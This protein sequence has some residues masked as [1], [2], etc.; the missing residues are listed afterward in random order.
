VAGFQQIA[1][2]GRRWH[3]EMK[4]MRQNL[5]R[6]KDRRVRQRFS[7]NAPLLVIAGDREIPAYTRDLSNLGVYFYL[8]S[9]DIGLVDRDFDFTLELPPEITLSTCC[10]IQCR[11]R[12]VRMET[13]LR[14]LTGVAAEILSY[15]IV[16]EPAA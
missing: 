8:G 2:H 10:L 4:G 9:D 7:L 1:S 12:K 11:G 5:A 3:L 6:A 13:G 16:R 14:D 15:S